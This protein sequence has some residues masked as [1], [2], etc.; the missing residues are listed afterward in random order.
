MTIKKFLPCFYLAIFVG[1]R[2]TAWTMMEPHGVPSGGDWAL[3]RT[4]A[5]F[6]SNTHSLVVDQVKVWRVGGNAL[7]LS[8]YNQWAEITRSEFAWLGGSAIALW[9]W[10][11]EISDNGAKGYDGTG[12]DFPR[13][14][15]V[16]RNIFHEIGVWEK[17][18]RHVI[19]HLECRCCILMTLSLV[20]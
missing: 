16:E 10:T 12:G 1:V 14:T 7:M 6:F 18:S 8:R 20:P 15:L 3:E 19:H 2:D 13:Y 9:G 17:Q 5:L 11:D 4:A